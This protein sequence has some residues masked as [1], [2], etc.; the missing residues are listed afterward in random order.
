MNK[1]N[2]HSD[3]RQESQDFEA[4]I[5]RYVR[6]QTGDSGVLQTTGKRR[7]EVPCLHFGNNRSAATLTGRQREIIR[8][9]AD[10]YSTRNIAEFLHISTKT[11]EKHR[12]ALM[13]KLD[14]HNVAILTR[15]AVSSGLVTWSLRAPKLLST[16][17]VNYSIKN[18]SR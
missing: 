8:F 16:I 11:V 18:G 3:S 2:N 13:K 6:N 15:Y 10:G 7:K 1:I 17:G 9:I 14:I 12:Q 4:S 5:S